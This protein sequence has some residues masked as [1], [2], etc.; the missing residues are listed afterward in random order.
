LLALRDQLAAELSAMTRLQD[1]ITRLVACTAL[2]SLLEEVLNATIPLQHAVSGN[3]QVFNPDSRVLEV[4]VQRGFQADFLEYF[5]SLHED[6]SA[7]GRALQRQERLI[8][9]ESWSRCASA[10][11]R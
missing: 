4:V 11:K 9:E 10:M 2:Q 8:I 7:Y 3:V 5:G 1:F 6:T